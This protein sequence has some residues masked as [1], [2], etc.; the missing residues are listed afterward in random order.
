MATALFITTP[1]QYLFLSS[2]FCFLVTFCDVYQP[3]AY[4]ETSNARMRVGLPSS[5]RVVCGSARYGGRCKY[6]AN[7]AVYPQNGEPSAR[8]T[9]A[10]PLTDRSGLTICPYLLQTIYTYPENF[11]AYKALVAAKYAGANLT[12]DPNFVFGQTNKTSEFLAKFPSGKV[13][14]FRNL[15]FCCNL[16]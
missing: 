10:E 9:A 5:L 3:V 12:V 6:F 13:S 8:E 4:R 2:Q 7:I 11:R 1:Y 16:V 15:L 14:Y